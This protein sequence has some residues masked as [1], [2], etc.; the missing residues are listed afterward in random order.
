VIAGQGSA[1]PRPRHRES[2][3]VAAVIAKFV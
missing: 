2:G 1:P 3:V